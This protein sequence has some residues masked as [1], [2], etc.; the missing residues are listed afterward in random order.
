M[1]KSFDFVFDVGGPNSYLAH[2]VMPDFCARTGAEARYVPVLLGGIFKATGNSAPLIRYQDAPAKWA[3]EQLEF[4]RFIATHAIEF[5][6]NPYFPPNS[7]L[8]MRVLTG[9]R[10]TPDFVPAI[11]AMM[12]GMW[13]DGLKLDE[14]ELVQSRL[15]DAG[16]NGAAM[17]AKA[18]DPEVKA[19]LI[20]ETEAAVA[21]GAFGVPTFYVGDEMFWGKERLA[22]V[23]AALALT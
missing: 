2:K 13:V 19:A 4:R 6:M 12:D 5:Q 14:P 22:Q 9:A 16:L 10:E 7:L 18:Q 17:V 1:T 21:R 15:D 8:V 23:E 20:T 11:E 3:Y